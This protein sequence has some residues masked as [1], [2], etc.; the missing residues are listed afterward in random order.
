PD[1]QPALS[2]PRCRGR[3][4]AIPGESPGGAGPDAGAFECRGPARQGSGAG[5]PRPGPGGGARV[6]GRAAEP[7]TRGGVAL[8]AG[9]AAVP[10]QAVAGVAAGAADGAGAAFRPPGGASIAGG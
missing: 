7:A 4:P 5:E 1:C 8:R 9:G 2:Q 10:G 6:P 3:A